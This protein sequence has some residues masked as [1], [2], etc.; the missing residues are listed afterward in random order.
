MDMDNIKSISIKRLEEFKKRGEQ[1]KGLEYRFLYLRISYAVAKDKHI[2]KIGTRAFGIF[3][4]I[5]T[6]MDEESIAYPSLRTIAYLASCSVKSAQEDIN[7][8]IKHGWLEKV[9][10]IKIGNG[11]FGNTKYR[12][13]EQDLI[14]GSKQFDFIKQP[15]VIRANGDKG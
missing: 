3:I 15:L 2:R 13:L 9:G 11:R 10:R 1:N 7:K 14:R 6:F 4:V 8:L 5:R 12:I